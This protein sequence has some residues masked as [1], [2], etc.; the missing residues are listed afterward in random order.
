LNF[1]QHQAY[2]TARVPRVRC[3][4]CGIKTVNVPWARPD[5]GFTLL[6]EALVMTMVSAMPVK[7]V[8]RMVGEHDTR[9]W[10]VVHHYVEQART[11]IDASGVTRIAIDETAARRGHDYLTLFVDIDQARVLFAT[12]GKD[13]A[14][15]AAFADDLTTHGGDPETISEVCIDMS[16]AFIKG[17]GESLPK[18]EITFDKFHAV[19]IVN[20]AVDQV[21]RAEQKRQ[22]LLRG[23]RYIWLRNPANLSQPQ[24]ATLDALPTRHLKTG[25]AYRIRLAFQELYDQPSAEM[26]PGFPLGVVGRAA[27]GTAGRTGETA[28]WSEVDLDVEPVCLDVEVATADRPRRGQTQRLLQQSC[29]THDRSLA[30]RPS[31][32]ERGEETTR[33]SRTKKRCQVGATSTSRRKWRLGSRLG[34]VENATY[35]RNRLSSGRG[36]GVRRRFAMRIPSLPRKGGRA[37]PAAKAPSI[38]LSPDHERELKELVRAHS[39]PQVTAQVSQARSADAQVHDQAEWVG[40]ECSQHIPALLFGGREQRPDD[41][42]ISRS[43]LGA[44]AAGDLLPQLHH[45]TIAFGLVVGERHGGIGQEA[46]HILFAGAQTKQEVMTHAARRRSAA[47]RFAGRADQRGLRRMEREAL[48]E[49]RIITSFDQCDETRGQRHALFAGEVRPMA[50]TAQ[51]TLHLARPVFALDRDQRLE[52]TQ[53]MRVA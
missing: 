31:C 20:D 52:F 40:G 43:V 6:F 7:A 48:R 13:A 25:R 51:Q 12:Q 39:T 46:E 38:Q 28:A 24:R 16:P 26:A 33:V 27:R 42:E 15:V 47:F 22:S 5:S 10:R 36:R 8:A 1:F 32:S 21:R 44:K 2:L 45:P 41:P 4:R 11:R 29:V 37:M 34:R 35:C 50:G 9:L 23:T 14:T 53:V 19:K 18:A 17:V 49:D 30:R 3:E